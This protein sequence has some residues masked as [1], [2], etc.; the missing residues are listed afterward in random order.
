[1]KTPPIEQLIA[2]DLDTFV[3]ALQEKKRL[4][5]DEVCTLSSYIAAN[6]M[7]IIYA[8]QKSISTA[9]ING[10]LGIISNWL[11]ESF[12]NQFTEE[13]F[14]TISKQSLELL[15]DISFDQKSKNYFSQLINN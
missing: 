12:E 4:T 1:M 10:V 7:R 2:K 14:M 5:I 6:F 9:E 8:K 13:D 15:K 3:M 11:N